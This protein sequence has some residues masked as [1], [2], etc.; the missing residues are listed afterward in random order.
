M[1]FEDIPKEEQQRLN[2]WY[3]KLCLEIV[4]S[5]N[6]QV[7]EIYSSYTTQTKFQTIV[8][9][10][11]LILTIMKD[12]VPDAKAGIAFSELLSCLLFHI[13]QLV[14]LEEYEKQQASFSIEELD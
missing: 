3:T 2:D 1:K 12:F 10:T 4:E 7:I 11:P 6:R 8:Y 9:M 13:G 5:S 14:M